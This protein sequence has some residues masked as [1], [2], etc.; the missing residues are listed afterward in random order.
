[1]IRLELVEGGDEAF[2]APAHNEIEIV[3]EIE[4]EQVVADELA[5][6]ERSLRLTDLPGPEHEFAGDLIG[7]GT[8]I[9]FG[10]GEDVPDDDEQFTG[11]SDDGLFFADTVR[12]TLKGFFPIGIEANGGPGGLNQ[13]GAEIAASLFGDASTPVGLAGGINSCAKAGVSDQFFGGRKASDVANSAQDGHGGEQAN[14]GEL[15][16]IG[17][18]V[19]PGVQGTE[20]GQF[21]FNF[22][23]LGVEMEQGGQILTDAQLF[24]RRQV[25]R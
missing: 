7:V 14:P 15:D 22:A 2:D 23:D 6:R 20:T 16:Q 8:A 17:H 1:M 11:D 24:G 12:E 9:G 25:K 13:N 5:G 21:G 19:S 4:F 3:A 18:R 10:G